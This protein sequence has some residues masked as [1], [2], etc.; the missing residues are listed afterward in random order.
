MAYAVSRPRTS[1]LR[2]SG[3]TPAERGGAVRAAEYPYEVVRIGVP[4]SP[5]DL[6]N[7]EVGLDQQLVRL[8][9]APFADPLQNCPPRLAPDDRGEVP[10]RE[11]HGP[12]DVLERD[13]LVV[14]FLD[15]AEYPG[16]EGLVL[17]PEVPPRR[18]PQASR[19]PRAEASGA[20]GPPLGSRPSSGGV[21][22]RGSRS[23]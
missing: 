3:T 9:H 4:H 23:A 14:A 17:E 7:R 2:A 16:D 22:R 19:A 1:G 18:P 21:R 20:K 12:W 15:E 6:L 8:R 11:S 5:A 10:R 13:R